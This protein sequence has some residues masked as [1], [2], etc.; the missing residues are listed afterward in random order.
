MSF[1]T[2]GEIKL[3][4]T[5]LI[6][7]SGET[8]GPINRDRLI[9]DFLEGK[10]P[11]SCHI[12]TYEL[13]KARDKKLT[14]TPLKE[15]ELIKNLTKEQQTPKMKNRWQTIDNPQ[16]HLFVFGDYLVLESRETSFLD[17]LKSFFTEPTTGAI[18]FSAILNVSFSNK[19]TGV[20]IE[21]CTFKEI[22]EIHSIKCLVSGSDAKEVRRELQR[23][24]VRIVDA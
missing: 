11:S 14:W 4:D 5:Y 21:A 2:R 19:K 10:L 18:P 7:A 1:S 3:Q 16:N 12:A 6:E 22:Y 15:S 13:S 23:E 17:T 24:D 20:E 9:T 8:Y